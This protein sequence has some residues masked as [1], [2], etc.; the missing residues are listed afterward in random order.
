[1][2]Y[3]ITKNTEKNGIEIY[4]DGKPAQEVRDALK[5]MRFRWH[6]VKK[7]WYGRA[8]EPAVV[9]ALG[10]D[11]VAAPV[12]AQVPAKASAA[13][14]TVWPPINLDG[15]E[16]NKKTTYGAE[17]AAVIRADLK[18]RGVTG[19]TIRA[20]KA[21][22]TDTITA[23]VT[24]KPEDFRSAEEAA[25]R[26]GWRSF[27]RSEE[28]GVKVGGVEYHRLYEGCETETRKYISCGSNYTD[29]SEG[30][31][32]PVLRAYFM[33][34]IRRFSFNEHHME[35]EKNPEVTAAALERLTAIVKIINSYNWNHSD[36]M[37]DY[38]DV[39]F[40]FDVDIKYP[41]GFEPREFMT[42]AERVQLAADLKAEEEAERQ[43]LEEWRKEEER[44]HEEA[45]RAEEQRQKDRAEVLDDL[46]VEDLTEENRFY[47]LGLAGGIGK[48][49][50][51]EE[52]RQ[53]EKSTIHDALV[54]RK[55][56][57]HSAAAFEKFS[58]LLLDDWDFLAGMGG[59][60]T[61]DS[62]VNNDN[63][64]QLNREQREAVR[65][66]SVDCVGVYLGDEL[67]LVINPE[68]YGYARYTYILT[69]STEIITP[70]QSAAKTA[71]EEAEEREP[72]Y[73][74]VPITEQA[75][76]LP[77]GEV[78]SIYQPDEWILNIMRHSIGILTAVEPGTWA[79]YS[80]VY[81]TI[82]SGRKTQRVFCA[83][84]KETV[85][86]CGLPL[87]LPES[88]IYR[89]IRTGTDATWKEY[90]DAHGQIRELIKFYAA[91][92]RKPVLDMVQR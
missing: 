15:I 52:I 76:E 50:S 4:F 90:R 33:D 45:Q 67:K 79:Q 48:E 89:N 71:E 75:D 57:F 46:T 68:G 74:P 41:A 23:T 81:L 86:F 12:A 30:S 1:M 38:F 66:Y 14:G 73:F 18:R 51:V 53:H 43:R 84:C 49:D 80:G 56:I 31:N 3:T 59:T 85:V 83:D 9:A 60:G 35:P 69:D 34:R 24:M 10:G 87:A 27:F 47:V 65:F 63:I 29:T 2:N 26:D 28:Y 37:T 20:G 78:V 64:M 36:S 11:P 8:D 54:T 16:N 92:G 61:N 58:R 42:E 25:A 88:V 6:G 91:N 5:A 22:Y 55:A 39:G 62:R 70:E 82:Q 72:F 19:V 7:C 21:T 17:F 13:S 44:R 40:Y 32:F 77:L